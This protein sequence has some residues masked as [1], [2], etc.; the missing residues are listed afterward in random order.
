MQEALSSAA[1]QQDQLALA[2]QVEAL[3]QSIESVIRGKAEVVTQTLVALFAQGHFLIEDVPG[4]GKTMLAQALARSLDAAF[5]RIQFTSDLLPSDIIGI[6]IFNPAS[7]EFEFKAGPL[8]ANV[9]LADEINRSTPKTQS[10]LLEAMN[11][12]Q[13]SVDNISHPLPRPFMVLATQ[14]PIEHHGTYPLPES[15]LDRFLMRVRMGYPDEAHEKEILQS[16]RCSHPLD[17]VRPVMTCEEVCEIQEKVRA[18]RVDASLADYLVRLVA[19]TRDSEELALGV[20]PR[21]TLLLQRA[22]QAHA[23]VSGRNYLIPDDVKSVAIPVLAHRVIPRVRASVG[24]KR[25]SEAETILRGI[26]E[27][28]PVPL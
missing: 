24:A 4:V 12:A 3:R 16:Q 26:L 20:S 6:S 7:S 2:G 5:R 9:V 13:A 17:R 22:A 15:Q 14:N 8:F 19:T 28:V 11:E 21:G 10:A 23:L 25:D 1:F 18:V 27:T